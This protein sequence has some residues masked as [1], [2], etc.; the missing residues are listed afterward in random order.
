M[1]MIWVI[2]QIR[3]KLHL[4]SNF[5]AGVTPPS[6][7]MYGRPEHTILLVMDTEFVGKVLDPWGNVHGENPRIHPWV[8][9][10]NYG[11]PPFV[12]LI[13]KWAIFKSYVQASKTSTLRG[14][15]F[16]DHLFFD[17]THRFS[18]RGLPQGSPRD[19]SGSASLTY[20]G[21]L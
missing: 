21:H 1:W 3:G 19:I 16:L 7:T 2:T 12:G 15:N 17:S 18:N 6:S 4:Q 14:R 20:T 9:E 10:N 11:K 5:V 13:Y 8:D